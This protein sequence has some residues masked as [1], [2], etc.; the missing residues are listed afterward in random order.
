MKKIT[1]FLLIIFSQFNGFGQTCNNPTCPN[2]TDYGIGEWIGY[3]Y[4]HAGGNSPP[5]PFATYKGCVNEQAIFDR[6]WGTGNPSCANNGDRF[7]VRYRMRMNF[8]AGRYTFTIGGDD[9][10]RLSIDGGASFIISDWSNHG[11]RTTASPC[12]FLSGTYDL[13]LEYYEDAGNARVSFNY[14]FSSAP[15]PIFGPSDWGNNQW[16]VCGFSG[17]NMNPSQNTFLG[18]YTQPALGGGNEGINTANFWST[19][20]SPSNAGTPANSG[21]L[22]YGCKVPN[23]YHMI[24]YKRRGFPCGLYQLSMINWDDPVE[25]YINGTMVWS[26]NQ[27]SGA[28]TCPTGVVGNYSLDHT[29]EI[30]VRHV[31]YGGNS[32]VTMQLTRIPPTQLSIDGSTL[33]CKINGGT[34][35][36]DFLDNNGRLIASVNPQ[37]N[38]LGDVTMTSYVQLAPFQID[39]CTNPQPQFNTAVLGRRWVITPEFQPTTNVKV[40]LYYSINE[41]NQL[42]SVANTNANPTDNL[43][44]IADLKLSKYHNSTNPALVNNIATDNCPSGV[45]TIFTPDNSGNITTLFAGFDPNGRYSEF[46]IN[47]FSEF[48]L[49]GSSINSPLPITL[50]SFTAQCREN[51]ILISWSTASEINSDYFVLERSK[52]GF[53]WDSITTIKAAGT[54]NSIQNYSFTD[55]SNTEGTIYYRLRQVDMDGTEELYGPISSKCLNKENKFSIYPNPA[56]NSFTIQLSEYGNNGNALI[57]IYDHIGKMMFKQEIKLTNNT[58]TLY[59]QN[60]NLPKG[61]YFVRLA[62]TELEYKPVKLVIE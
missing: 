26:C 61:I 54:S 39:A 23:D 62:N 5:N 49:H 36:Y 35:F 16:L 12:L 15:A 4:D 50:I 24:T 57:E 9:G 11:Y 28:N 37:G 18:H 47:S 6:N 1:I 3:V 14:T 48:W 59:F 55:K 43:T 20:S 2:Q 19:N 60:E 31:E 58:Y 7:A 41:Y 34:N 27:W 8:T 51:D 44:G 33:T 38:N 29:T 46:T 22:L 45:T 13:V 30:E 40:R 53:K 21:N 42:T 25:I 32:N 56:S 17:T 10:V 52:D